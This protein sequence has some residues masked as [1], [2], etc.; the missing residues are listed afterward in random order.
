MD[1]PPISFRIWYRHLLFQLAWVQT[2]SNYNFF[3]LHLMQE[4][5]WLSDRQGIKTWLRG[6]QDQCQFS[7]AAAGQDLGGRSATKS[8]RAWSLSAPRRSGG[9]WT[10]AGGG[11]GPNQLS[12]MPLL[13]PRSWELFSSK[14]QHLEWLFVKLNFL[15]RYI[16]LTLS[17]FYPFLSGS[18][19]LMWATCTG[20][21][22]HASKASRSEYIC[23]FVCFFALL[24]CLFVCLSC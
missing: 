9:G 22:K 15:D 17:L 19:K 6:C 5:Q 7:L 20:S 21:A 13:S 3:L 10:A 4:C 23:F 2:R 16:I 14:K 8:A 12:N 1:F 18:R 11:L 24:V